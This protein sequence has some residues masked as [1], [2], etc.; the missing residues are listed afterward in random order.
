M[1]S[2]ALIFGLAAAALT[3]PAFADVTV[4][5][6]GATAFR[7]AA[8]LSI[9]SQYVLSGQPF[10]FAHDK[11]SA[12]DDYAN[13]TYSVWIGTFPGVSGTTTIRCSF[14]GSVEGIRAL[15]V[16]PAA[17]PE[18]LLPSVL[19]SVTAII[20]GEQKAATTTPREK[21][22]SEIAFS[23][24]SVASTPYAASPLEPADSAAGVVVFAMV[25]NQGSP[26]TNITSQQFRALLTNG[27]QPLSVFTGNAADTTRVYVTGRNDGSG[28]RTA[29]MAESGHG[30]ATPVKQYT[31]LVSSGETISE[32]QLVPAGGANDTNPGTA[33]VQPWPGQDVKNASIVWGQDVDGNGGYSSGSGLVSVLG[34]NA[35]AASKVWNAAHTTS[36]TRMFHLAT[37]ISLNDAVTARD[38]GAI[39][40][41][42]NGVR[43]DGIAASGTT[44]SATDLAKVTE[45]SYTAWSYQQMYRRPSLG[46]DPVTVYDGI[47]G[48]I[49][50][51]LGSAGISISDMK[52][53]REV[54]GGV[55]A[56]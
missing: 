5:I 47:K 20:G 44:M 21:A 1:K 27:Y 10:K 18:Y 46:A 6:T 45:G 7:K 52:V 32:I 4:E 53:G 55:V 30:I 14:N 13:S 33:G 28:T 56:P 24:V 40:C 36:S 31:A 19:D 12:A 17:D 16:S 2:K 26:L 34:R 3:V 38:A 25:T 54:D 50:T 49:G 29:Y 41:G 51:N 35:T 48:A 9:H 8:L 22:Q 42:Y 23:D 39:I 37:W 43:L 11:T 15:V